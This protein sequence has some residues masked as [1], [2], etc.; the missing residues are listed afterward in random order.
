MIFVGQAFQPDAI[1]PWCRSSCR[2]EGLAC[3][4]RSVQRVRVPRFEGSLRFEGRLSCFEGGLFRSKGGDV[5]R[6]HS[7]NEFAALR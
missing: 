3:G 7:S 1:E 5:L 6:A 2:K 4:P